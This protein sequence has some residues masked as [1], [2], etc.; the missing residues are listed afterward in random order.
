MTQENKH[1]AG[2]WKVSRLYDIFIEPRICEI[3]GNGVYDY[4]TWEANAHLI[5]AAPD[6]LEALENLLNWH[7]TKSPDFLLRDMFVKDGWKT[8]NKARG[9]A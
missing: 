4:D 9:Q 7:E 5:A 6:L 2:P 3:P 1:I 8:I